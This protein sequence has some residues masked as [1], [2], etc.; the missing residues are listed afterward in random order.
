MQDSAMT[1]LHID[2]RVNYCGRTFR[3]RGFSPMSV[4]PQTVAL[5]ETST[6]RMITVELAQLD[7]SRLVGDAGHAAA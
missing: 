7:V 5:E 1:E 6:G 3:V 4:Q 2:D